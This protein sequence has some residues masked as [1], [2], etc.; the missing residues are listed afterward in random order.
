MDRD[1][2]LYSEDRLLATVGDQPDD[3]VEAL[4]GRVMESVS[5]FS[6]GN[7]QSDDITLLTL[8]YKGR[9]ERSV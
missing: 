8:A 9:E 3:S 5:S 7:E 2:Q 1:L 4:A 6:D